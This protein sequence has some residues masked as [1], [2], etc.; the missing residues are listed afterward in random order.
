MQIES[1]VF[2][3]QSGQQILHRP[4]DLVEAQSANR[5]GLRPGENEQ[6]LHQAGGLHDGGADLLSV[7]A[8]AVAGIQTGEQKIAVQHDAGQ[9]VVEVMHHTPGQAADCL[10][11]LSLKQAFLGNR[12]AGGSGIFCCLRLWP[13]KWGCGIHTAYCGAGRFP[14]ETP[15]WAI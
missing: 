2:A 8:P 14:K 5:R 3:D 11:S 6:L 9:Q 7:T 1:D 15:R 13:R 4:G 12:S 10:P